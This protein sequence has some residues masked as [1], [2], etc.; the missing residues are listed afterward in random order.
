MFKS[1]MNTGVNSCQV[2]K[3]PY[4]GDYV[5]EYPLTAFLRLA[6]DTL[7]HT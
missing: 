2:S 3:N 4:K 1:R 7:R 5:L 6:K